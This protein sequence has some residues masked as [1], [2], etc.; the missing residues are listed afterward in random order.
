MNLDRQWMEEAVLLRTAEAERRALPEH[1]RPARWAQLRRYIAS[2]PPC[3]RRQVATT[4]HDAASRQLLH[5]ESLGRELAQH[6]GHVCKTAQDDTADAEEFLHSVQV[7]G[8]GC[9]T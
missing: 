3:R 7:W 1:D 5:L 9:W 2:V 4:W 8:G 6:W